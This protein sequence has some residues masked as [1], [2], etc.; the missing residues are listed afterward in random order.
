MKYYHVIY[1]SS[2][3]NLNGS[4]GF[5]IRTATEGIPQDYLRTVDNA[6]NINLIT[7]DVSDCK[8]PSP[9]E[10]L[11]DGRSILS[12]PPR[13][14]YLKLDVEGGAPLFAVGRNIELGFTE[15]FYYKD[16][17][18]NISG[19]GGRTGNFLIDLYLFEE[20]PQ[21][22]VF[23]IFSDNSFIPADPSPSVNNQEMAS[24]AT[25]DPVP[26]P[27]SDVWPLHEGN[28]LPQEKAVD[29]LFLLLEGRFSSPKKNI[30]AKYPW[31][32]TH[33]LI[34]DAMKLL[35]N[36][37]VGDFTFS[38]NYS[39]NGY[40]V[41]AEL[42]FV[43]EY[44]D[45]EFVGNDLFVDLTNYTPQTVESKAYRHIIL[46]ALKQ[47]ELQTVR[48]LFGWMMSDSY[49]RVRLLKPHTNRVLFV[50]GRQPEQF[51]LSMLHEEENED[52]ELLENLNRVIKENPQINKHP[53]IDCLRN[54]L[55]MACSVEKEDEETPQDMALLVNRIEIYLKYISITQDV[56]SEFG[57]HI[58]EV[59]LS[60][61]LRSIEKLG[62]GVVR[63]YTHNMENAIQNG[64]LAPYFFDQIKENIPQTLQEARNVIDK[65]QTTNSKVFDLLV[66]NFSQIFGGLYNLVVR[67]AANQ[68]DKKSVANTLDR[69]L[70]NPLQSAHNDPT[71]Q[72]YE[73]LYEVLNETVEVDSKNYREVLNLLHDTGMLNSTVAEKV[74]EQLFC[75]QSKREIVENVKIL[76]KFWH[77]KHSQIISQLSKYPQMDTLTKRNYIEAALELSNDLKIHDVIECL[78][79]NNYKDDDI[80]KYLSKSST[81]SAAYT[82]FKRKK[83]IAHF[84]KALRNIFRKKGKGNI[85]EFLLVLFLTFLLSIF[86]SLNLFAEEVEQ[87]YAAYGD[88]RNTPVC[89]IVTTKTLNVRTSPSIYKGKK[90]KKRKDNL[91][92][93]MNK[94][95]TVF[96]NPSSL[97]QTIDKI[98][99]IAFSNQGTTY[100]TNL[101]S[102]E[103]T[104][105]PHYIHDEKVDVTITERLL[106]FTKSA[107]PWMLLVFT[108]ICFFVTFGI[109]T[110]DKD[111]IRGEPRDSTGMRPMFMYSLRPYKFF[112][113]L[114]LRVFLAGLASVFIL[115]FIGGFIWLILWIVKIIMWV[116][117]I[118]GWVLLIGGFLALFSKFGYGLLAAIIGG[119]IVY[120]E[121][122]M[123][124]FG[125]E[126]VATGIAYLEVLNVWDFSV[127]LVKRYW[128]DALLISLIP[129]VLFLIAAVIML[130]VAGVLRAY[131]YLTTKRYNIKYPC[132]IC[133]KPSE[134]AK[135]FD[136]KRGKGKLPLPCNLRP[137]IYGLLHITHPVTGTKLPTLLAN[138]RDKLQRECPHCGELIRFKSG[139]E[140]H[141]GFVGLPGAGKTA[142]LS[143][144]IGELQ[145]R[146]KERGLAM[147]FTGKVD[148]DIKECVKYITEEGQLDEQHLPQKTR[149]NK[150]KASIQ[151]IYPRLNENVPYILYFNDVS[152]ESFV[153]E[154]Y[155]KE[156][157]RFSVDV[158][159]VLFLVD[160]MT[161]SFKKN[162]ISSTFKAW[163][164]REVVLNM[165]NSNPKDIDETCYSLVNVL[166]SSNRDLG[167]IHFTFVLVKSDLD[168]MKGIDPSDQEAI[169]HFMVSDMCLGNLIDNAESQFASVSYVAVSVYNKNDKGIKCLCDKLI[170]Q[171]DIN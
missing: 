69:N 14:F 119:I 131:E 16:K 153:S 132:P 125:D 12:V 169:R 107:A 19:K 137:G 39:G 158:E 78:K 58:E 41:P 15:L 79:Q 108:V 24:I 167:K 56:I 124:S 51:R 23:Q 101:G 2:Q 6:V 18:G 127:E 36:D 22:D 126:C 111:S 55:D 4:N 7:N 1:T 122:P 20:R 9:K 17:D 133:H 129:I 92:F 143:G 65:Y 171:L 67:D 50:Y 118:L 164:E 141:I 160:P 149:T 27:V 13:Y 166:R 85:R 30:V 72:K 71:F 86:G 147:P 120:F 163:L 70:L 90:K 104:N 113:G 116:L 44:Y 140:K 156:L 87:T 148:K 99:W 103:Q 161:M 3:K 68:N 46:E 165:R 88:A 64:D 102:L 112:T 94:G 21:R 130:I 110:P 57:N 42:C 76:D 25:G 100:F 155:D 121:D 97:P 109:V 34:S 48:Q 145:T 82:S 106:G 52:K 152:G 146:Q 168:Y 98:E 151:C 93:K 33:A 47:G 75:A 89:Y 73:Q 61:P 170:Q 35:P 115:L 59:L 128:I 10:L 26:F 43:N 60:N 32:Q 54:D 63:K 96:V 154:N 135:Y 31:Q 45:T 123:K 91:A 159:N 53:F 157:L 40:V 81:F 150:M 11:D 95:D 28:E 74:K 38:T 134:P 136:E 142:L 8:V 84:F 62:I 29:L 5:G 83:A 37:F 117:V 114:S 144:I 49:E 80:D 105:N 138:G 66:T 77:Q 139:T 162:E